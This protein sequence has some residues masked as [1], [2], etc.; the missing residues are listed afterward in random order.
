ML[1]EYPKK[2]NER[3]TPVD[4]DGPESLHVPTELNLWLELRETFGRCV[5]LLLDW[6]MK[7]S[8]PA[9]LGMPHPFQ[10]VSSAR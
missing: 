9:R 6:L 2:S 7:A 10:S 8:A 3:P 5:M 1:A 4:L